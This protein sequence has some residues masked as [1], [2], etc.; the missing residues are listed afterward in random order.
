MGSGGERM[1][2]M[3]PTARF[4]ENL[5]R[6]AIIE[7]GLVDD[8]AWLGRALATALALDP[9]TAALR[10]LGASVAVGSPVFTG[11]GRQRI[12]HHQRAVGRSPVNALARVVAAAP[13]LVTA[14]G[15]D[16]ADAG[17]TNDH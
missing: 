12:R 1:W 14:L 7:D 10:Q 16:V 3:D 13:E 9:K 5:R 2:G 15:Y 17:R 4:P 11:G 6:L 8:Q